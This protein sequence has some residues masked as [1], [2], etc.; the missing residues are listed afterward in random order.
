MRPVMRP[1]VRQSA[2]TAL[3][4]ACCLLLACC[5]L[6]PAQG[7]EVSVRSGPDFY[8]ACCDD[9]V[10]VIHVAAEGF[11]LHERDWRPARWDGT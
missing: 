9:S 4:P 11:A 2:R 10:D 7:R 6:R 8:A 5:L 1:V 3:L